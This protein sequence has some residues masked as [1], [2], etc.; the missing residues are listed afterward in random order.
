VVGKETK[1]MRGPYLRLMG[2][3]SLLDEKTSTLG[4]VPFPRP[5]D[6]EEEQA[7]EQ[8]KEGNASPFVFVFPF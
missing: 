5:H 3:L 2:L 7:S 4:G 6:E 1:A 8:E